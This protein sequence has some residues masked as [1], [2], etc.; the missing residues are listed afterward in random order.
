MSTDLTTREE[1]QDKIMQTA[2]RIELLRLV[3][4]LR[5]LPRVVRETKN[6]LEKQEA[7]VKNIKKWNED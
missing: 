4:I 1:S 3:G 6:L 5:D 7:A 2:S